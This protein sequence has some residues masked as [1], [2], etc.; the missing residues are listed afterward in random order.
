[1]TDQLWSYDKFDKLDMITSSDSC[2]RIMSITNHKTRI[3]TN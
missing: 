1:M 3:R 2:I